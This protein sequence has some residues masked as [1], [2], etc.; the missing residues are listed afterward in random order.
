MLLLA[1]N[2]E[3]VARYTASV[4]SSYTKKDIDTGIR[5][6]NFGD[7]NRSVSA[8][9]HLELQGF[10]QFHNTRVLCIIIKHFFY[11]FCFS[12]YLETRCWVDHS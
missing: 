10:K 4:S 8:V 6:T 11:M 5:H 3:N 2:V 7:D 12:C 9:A 1:Y